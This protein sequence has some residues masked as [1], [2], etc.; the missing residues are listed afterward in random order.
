MC[1]LFSLQLFAQ[2]T[3]KNKKDG[4][5][6]FKVVK[7]IEATEVQSQDRTGTCWSFSALSFIESEVIRVGNGKHKLSEMY[8]VRMAYYD[9][10]IKY[11]EESLLI[12]SNNVII[13]E[14]LNKIIN[15]KTKINSP[16]EDQA[17]NH[18]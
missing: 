13:K 11:V 3:L 6:Y 7:D 15:N 9:K 2:D 16:K 5:Y 1:S 4:K 8:I 10:A 14:H 18:D 12:D 17:G